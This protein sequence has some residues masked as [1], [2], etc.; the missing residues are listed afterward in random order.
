MKR[1]AGLLIVT[2]SLASVAC[3]TPGR[4]EAE[5]VAIAV[6]RFRQADNV[7]KPELADALRA[8]ACSVEDVCAARDACLASAEPTARALRLKVEV[9]SVLGEVTAGTLPRDSARARELTAKLDEASGLLKEGF[10]ALGT[11]DERVLALKRTY[12]F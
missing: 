9:E 8:T 5:S 12:R 1:A 4:R 6:E 11:C 2:A 3:E 7:R 10:E